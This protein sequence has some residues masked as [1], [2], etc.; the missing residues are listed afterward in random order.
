MDVG[1]VRT[2]KLLLLGIA[3]LL[4]LP[5]N[6]LSAQERCDAASYEASR[7]A[8]KRIGERDVLLPITS[9]EWGVPDRWSFTARYIH[10]MNEDPGALVKH[11]VGISASPGTAGGR[12]AAGSYVLIV[13]GGKEFGFLIECRVVVLRTWG[14]PLETEADRTLAGV[15]LRGSLMPLCNIGIGWYTQVSPSGGSSDPIVGVHFGLGL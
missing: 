11:G 15:E 6:P 9:I 8:M 14:S 4:L 13:P 1:R 12:L 7:R 5:A 2:G 10:Q 3:V